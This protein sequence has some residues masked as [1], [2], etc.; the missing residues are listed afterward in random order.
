MLHAYLTRI[1]YS[2]RNLPFPP[3]SPLRSQPRTHR[4]HGP[5]PQLIVEENFHAWPAQLSPRAVARIK[6]PSR[7]GQGE[8]HESPGQ[9]RGATE[10]RPIPSETVIRWLGRVLERFGVRFVVL[11]LVPRVV[12]YHCRRLYR[13]ALFLPYPCFGFGSYRR[14]RRRSKVCTDG[15]S[16]DSS[17]L[18]CKVA[19]LM[20]G[21]I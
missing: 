17:C 12:L 13:N 4:H 9:R 15:V 18:D 11:V 2:S 21:G 20:E 16:K 1:R 7:T 3:I 10:S 6:R 14:V 19:I 8:R 5:R